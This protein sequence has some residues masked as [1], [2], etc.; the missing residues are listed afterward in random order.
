MTTGTVLIEDALRRIGAHS[1]ASPAQ[2][3]TI[4][5]GMDILNSM[6]Q[7]WMSWGIDIQTIPIEEPGEEVSEP[8]DAKNAIIDNL[9]IA[10]SPNFDNGT[11]VVSPQLK[12]NA[13]MGF[14]MVKTL[15]TKF[16]IP[17]KVPSS[18]LPLGAGNAKGRLRFVF[19]RGRAISG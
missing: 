19:F 9:A 7:L 14:N 11:T 5:D 13:L 17:N 15:Y 1:I 8:I 6:L 12:S 4:V 18:T 10:M 2:P 16:T 3:E